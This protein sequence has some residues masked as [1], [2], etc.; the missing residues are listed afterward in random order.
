MPLETVRYFAC[1]GREVS[2]A[3]ACLPF[4][5][6]MSSTW[7]RPVILPWLREEDSV[8]ADWLHGKSVYT[9]FPE[10]LHLKTDFGIRSERCA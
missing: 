6:G 3:E 1:Q 5:L 7:L 4:F 10:T 8:S 9:V 2:S